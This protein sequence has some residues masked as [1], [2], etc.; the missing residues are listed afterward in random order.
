MTIFYLI[1]HGETDWNV[2]GR[3]QGHTDIP[4]NANGREQ[5]RRLAER[6]RD[7]RARFDAIYSSDL[8]RAFE[9]ARQL[10]E[11]LGLPVR[12]LPALREIDIGSWGGLTSAE[13][14]AQDSETLRRI[15]RGEDL[16]RG[17]G[18]RISDLRRRVVAQL[19]RLT[20]AHPG[21]TLALVSHG[22]VVRALLD[23][24]LQRSQQPGAMRGH[25][26]NTSISIVVRTPGGW[27]IATVN[28]LAHLEDGAAD[29]SLLSDTPDDV[30]RA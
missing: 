12:Q 5:A 26:G 25:I 16:P 20:Q 29:P 7:D 8:A 1:R 30:E 23:H 14:R 15:E 3:W 19:E 21:Q 4:L 6:L 2:E 10:G 9:T 17:G 11:A 13:I 27:D 18:E 28:D 22:G 24:V